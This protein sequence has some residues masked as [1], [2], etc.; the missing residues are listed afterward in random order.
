MN[1]YTILERKRA[2]EALSVDEIRAV[3]RGAA[4]GSW[5][6]AQLA[7]FLM[8]AAIH[9]LDS[10]ETGALTEAML[11]SGEQWALRDRFPDVVDKHS[12]GGVGDKV[13]LILGPVLAAC[14]LPVVMLTGR[15]LG[16]TGGTADKLESIP[17]LDLLLDQGRCSRLL[18]RERLA[19][20]VAS[21][22]IA[23]AD[24]RLYGL[25]D[26]TATV[27][28]L[29][30]VVGSILSKKLAVG[31][32]AVVFD[33]KVGN[34]AVFPDRSQA[35]ALARLM[36][37]TCNR[38]GCSSAA[39]LTDMSQPLGR[40][41]G[42]AAEVKESLECLEGGG[43]PRLMTLVI[44]LCRVVSEKVGSPRDSD[45][46]QEAVDSGRARERFDIWAAAQGA[47]PSW[48]RTP[49][50]ELAPVEIE[51]EAS[52]DGVLSA[53]DTRKLG[54]MLQAAA[55]ASGRIDHGVSLRYDARLGA[56]VRGGETLGCFYARSSDPDLANQLAACFE[57]SEVGQVP[58]LIVE[59]VNVSD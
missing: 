22:A 11:G 6:D 3:V 9:E 30:L 58:D 40:W 48:L 45:E 4:D 34:G 39:L 55:T 50:F 41:S 25:R 23:P 10:H 12:T 36:V 51:I 57:I 15:A 27:T 32:A 18:E 19:I 47:D 44:E 49:S 26:Q 35:L 16:H 29:P 7:A 14:G 31:P 33:V 28:S 38:L 52:A 5:S 1:P 53:V 20:G 37:D 54:L 46:L 42:H 2:G 24:Q 43:D 59:T 21:G 13:S 56:T 8:A 17:G